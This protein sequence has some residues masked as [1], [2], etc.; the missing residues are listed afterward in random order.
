MTYVCNMH[1]ILKYRSTVKKPRIISV[2]LSYDLYTLWNLFRAPSMD[3]GQM[4][5]L[6]YLSTCISYK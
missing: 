4:V 5:A 6:T 2:G 3:I 1:L